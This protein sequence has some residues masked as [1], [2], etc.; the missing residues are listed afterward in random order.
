MSSNRHDK[1]EQDLRDCLNGYEE[2]PPAELWEDIASAIAQEEKAAERKRRRPIV[3]WLSA[4]GVAAGIALCVIALNNDDSTPGAPAPMVAEKVDKP[5]PAQPSEAEALDSDTE[6]PVST[7]MARSQL[8]MIE[9]K[10]RTE[11][12]AAPGVTEPGTAVT[13]SSVIEP[14]PSCSETL[15]KREEQPT[16]NSSPLKEQISTAHSLNKHV[17]QLTTRGSGR[18]SASV[19]GSGFASGRNVVD[20]S[21]PVITPSGMFAAP[22]VIGEQ[23]KKILHNKVPITVGAMA[24]YRISDRWS[25][26]AGVTFS[27]QESTITTSLGDVFNTYVQTLRYVGIP[28]G[29]SY[30]IY[31]NRWLDAYATAH[32]SVDKCIQA[33]S[34][35]T[36]GTI[37]HPWVYGAGIA[38]GVQTNITPNLGVYV[39]PG[40]TYH[41]IKK[42]NM[43]TRYDDS[44]VEFDLRMGLRWTF[45]H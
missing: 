44:P 20:F 15:A 30:T 4:M 12:P 7:P 41:M 9:P 17:A 5:V 1:F 24:R 11:S 42:G 13:Q 35:R 37:E 34:T 32:L 39:E 23:R 28:V 21:S 2:M 3:A 29:A 14:A 18:W 43:P 31:R 26:D 6:V 36:Y 38:P 16:E 19:Y 22:M 27:H 33:R 45:N 40:I 10:I 8:T 25:L